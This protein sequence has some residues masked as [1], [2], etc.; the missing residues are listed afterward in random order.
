MSNLKQ[1]QNC[2]NIAYINWH[3]DTFKLDNASVYPFLLKIFMDTDTY[4]YVKQRKS[5]QDGQ[6]VFFDI[7]KHFFGHDHVA[8][9]AIEAERKLQSSH[10]DSEKKEWD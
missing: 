8:M 4:V 7:H 2:L 5:I 1:T 10:Y 9:Q 6:F 3:Y